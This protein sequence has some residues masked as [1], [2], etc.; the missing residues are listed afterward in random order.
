MLANSVLV[1]GHI[2][3]DDQPMFTPNLSLLNIPSIFETLVFSFAY[4]Y[5]AIFNLPLNKNMLIL[6]KIYFLQT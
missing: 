4:K 5:F 2:I 6:Q 3:L 1:Q